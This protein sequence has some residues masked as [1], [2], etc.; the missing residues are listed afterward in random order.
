MEQEQSDK[1]IPRIA[2]HGTINAQP[3]IFWGFAINIKDPKRF[4]TLIENIENK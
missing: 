4:N 1:F 3:N 2:Q